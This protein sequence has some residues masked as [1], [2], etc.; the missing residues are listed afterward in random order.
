M[1]FN[2]E[3]YKEEAGKLRYLDEASRRFAENP[4]TQETR[5]MA[6]VALFNRPTQE[7]YNWNAPKVGHL[8]SD[9]ENTILFTGNP[10][11]EIVP[12]V[13]NT[14]DN[15]DDLLNGTIAP[16]WGSSLEAGFGFLMNMPAIETDKYES[17]NKAHLSYAQAQTNLSTQNI[18]ALVGDIAND[19]MVSV[20]GVLSSEEIAR[21]YDETVIPARQFSFVQEIATGEKKDKLDVD[22]TKH[23]AWNLVE[24]AYEVDG[25]G[26]YTNLQNVS[27]AAKAV[28]YSALQ[29]N[30]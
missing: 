25:E 15:L 24:N 16:S 13:D 1:T 5:D 22:K 17:V 28:A 29:A 18:G 30:N 23:Y 9:K 19:Y 20:Q 3:K 14:F 4:D 7:V 2:F 27:K 11:E 12:F 21:L 6:S 8:L 10:D 26:S